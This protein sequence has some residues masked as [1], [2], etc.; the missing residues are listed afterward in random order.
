MPHNKGTLL[1]FKPMAFDARTLLLVSDVHSDFVYPPHTVIRHSCKLHAYPAED[2]NCGI[3]STTDI[4]WAKQFVQYPFDGFFSPIL[5]VVQVLGPTICEGDGLRSHSIYLWGAVAPIQYGFESYWERRKTNLWERVSNVLE[6]TYKLKI[7]G[8]L[9]DAL[10]NLTPTW[11][12]YGWRDR[13]E[14]KSVTESNVPDAGD[15]LPF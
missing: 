12:R 8:N 3:L 2:H 1:A 5:G 15:G 4:E 13:S 14:P 9:D 7:W 11:K 6:G 10:F